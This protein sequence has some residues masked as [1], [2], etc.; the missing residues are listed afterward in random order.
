[1]QDRGNQNALSA[2]LNLKLMIGQNV[3]LSILITPGFRLKAHIAGNAVLF[4]A[5][6]ESIAGIVGQ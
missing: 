6:I 5:A 2:M 3:F 1:M 4:K